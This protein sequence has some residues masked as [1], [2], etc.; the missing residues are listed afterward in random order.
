MKIPPVTMTYHASS[1]DSEER[2]RQRLLILLREL[3][4]TNPDVIRLNRSI[5]SSG[6][7]DISL[8]EKILNS[9]EGKFDRRSIRAK[10]ILTDLMRM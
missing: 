8:C 6:R 5:A 2:R 1:G 9:L 10:R 3:A 7:V 4:A